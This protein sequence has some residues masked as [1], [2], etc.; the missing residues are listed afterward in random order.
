MSERRLAELLDQ[1]ITFEWAT[2]VVLFAPLPPDQ[3]ARSAAI[4]TAMRECAIPAHD[5]PFRTEPGH[6]TQRRGNLFR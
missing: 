3:N 6:P 1:T 5:Q 2:R 4:G